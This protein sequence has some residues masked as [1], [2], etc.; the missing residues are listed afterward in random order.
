MT[1]PQ[2]AKGSAYE[3]DVVA[4]LQANGFPNA[5]RLY[6]A[7]RQDDRG[8]ITIG[9]PSAGLFVLEAKNH[10]THDFSGWLQEA[11]VERQ[12]AG[13]EFGFVVAKRRG[14]GAS[15]SYALMTLQ[16][17]CKIMQYLTTPKEGSQ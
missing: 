9:G 1:N 10:K 4:Y 12:N 3:R 6:G 13:A 2:K 14:K 7:G 15:E 17:L 5:Q 8:D 16:Q 11:E